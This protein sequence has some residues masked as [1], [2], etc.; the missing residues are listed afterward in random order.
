MVY[1]DSPLNS[2]DDATLGLRGEEVRSQLGFVCCLCGDGLYRDGTGPVHVLDWGNTRIRRV[3]RAPLG[4]EPYGLTEGAKGARE[5]P[6]ALLR[7]GSSS[8]G[9]LAT[10][11]RQ[12]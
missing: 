12:R 9:A 10:T 2:M 5:D 8:P 3:C 1:A 6:G 7:A 4:A 11:G